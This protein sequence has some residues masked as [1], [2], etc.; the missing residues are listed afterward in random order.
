MVTAKNV[1]LSQL[2]QHADNKMF[3]SLNKPTHCALDPRIDRVGL[4]D[5]STSIA[6]RLNRSAQLLTYPRLDLTPATNDQLDRSTRLLTNLLS[7]ATRFL[8]WFNDCFND[9]FMTIK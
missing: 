5:R 1:T 3:A 7:C 2:L 8:N 9:C 6:E 4:Y